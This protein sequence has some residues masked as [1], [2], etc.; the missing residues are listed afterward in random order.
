MPDFVEK[1]ATSVQRSCENASVKSN[2]KGQNNNNVQFPIELWVRH[3]D[4]SVHGFGIKDIEGVD[5][6]WP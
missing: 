3:R 1:T 6:T 2:S 4:G 5:S